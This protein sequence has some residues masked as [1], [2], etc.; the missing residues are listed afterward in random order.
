[1]SSRKPTLPNASANLFLTD[2]GLETTLVFL[3]G[4]E[5]PCFAA[6][7]LLKDEKGYEAIKQYYIRYLN[8]ARDLQMNFI[9]ESPTWRANPD[10]AEKIGYPLSVLPDLNEKAIRLLADLRTEYQEKIPNIIISGCVG[11]RG[12][13]Y[14]PGSTMNADEAEAYHSTQI[15]IF[16]RTPVDMVSAITMNYV[17]EAIGIARAAGNVN[18]P[19]VI[20]FTVETDGR[21][22]TGMTLREAI[23]Q[24]DKSAKQPPLYFMI[25]CAHPTHF[26]TDLRE[27]EKAAW[28]KRIKGL[29]ANA[30][31]KSHA[32]LDESTV[33]D[34]GDPQTL[35]TEHRI[36]KEMMPHLNVFGGCCG[37]D[38]EHVHAIASHIKTVSGPSLHAWE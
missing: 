21:L 34:R 31:C 10:W 11:P 3:E 29:R 6:F 38:E 32:E 36:L 27:G 33:L 15:N 26:L 25:N 9:L 37:T 23:E 2:G 24:V 18:L 30:S 8:I 7:D 16:S 12:D 1:M 5:L 28:T 35:G 19:V 22:A 17:E 4:Y 20:S 13:G 14:K